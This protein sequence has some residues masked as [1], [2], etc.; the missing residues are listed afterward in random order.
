ML[1]DEL[2]PG[3]RTWTNYYAEWKDDVSSYALARAGELV[4]ID[5]LLAA[6]QWSALEAEAEG[7]ELHVLLTVHWHARSSAEVRARFPAARVWAHS[8][9]RAA[10][11]RRVEPT[12]VFGVGEELPGGVVAL[13][14]RPRT[15]VL[16]W[17]AAHRALIAGDALVGDGAEGGGLR[18]CKAWWLPQSTSLE[19]LR[20]ALRSTLDLPVELVLVSHGGSIYSA[21]GAELSRALGPERRDPR[22]QRSRPSPCR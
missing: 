5:P 9:D 12:D 22:S 19:D 8:R 13:E 21:A 20:A 1:G 17:D 11:A 6:D 3:L 14:A 10:I 18:T 7:R 16:F 15:E 4:L 2:R